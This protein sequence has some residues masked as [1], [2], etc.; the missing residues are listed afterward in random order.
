MGDFDLPLGESE[1]FLGE[2]TSNTRCKWYI[3]IV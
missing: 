2:M 3:A 1:E